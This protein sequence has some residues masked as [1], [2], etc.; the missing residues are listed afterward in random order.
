MPA[1]LCLISLQYNKD[2]HVCDMNAWM[3][4]RLNAVGTVY[5][6]QDHCPE[7]WANLMNQESLSDLKSVSKSVFLSYNTPGVHL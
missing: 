1:S 7:L 5:N 6:I 2:I 4:Y 3:Y